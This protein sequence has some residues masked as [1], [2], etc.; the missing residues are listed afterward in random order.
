[1]LAT[2]IGDRFHS[3]VWLYGA[4]SLGAALGAMLAGFV[5]VPAVGSSA[6]IAVGAALLLIVGLSMAQA[7]RRRP[8][9]LAVSFWPL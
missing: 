1:M 2:Q 6:T 5:F 7:W 9:W 8:V 3:G 4:N